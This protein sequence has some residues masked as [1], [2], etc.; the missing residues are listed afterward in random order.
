MEFL[1]GLTLKRRIGG[2]ALEIEMVLSMAI[3]NRSI[4]TIGQ[5]H[6]GVLRL[7]RCLRVR[8]SDDANGR[9]GRVPISGKAASGHSRAFWTPS[10]PL[11]LPQ[12]T[13]LC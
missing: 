2:K 4:E 12:P 1:D 9:I 8:G 3:E 5:R 13:W 6:R 10:L 11:P 7:A